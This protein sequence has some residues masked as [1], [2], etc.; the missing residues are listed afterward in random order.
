MNTTKAT[1]KRLNERFIREPAKVNDELRQAQMER[2]F[3]RTIDRL[4]T[5]QAAIEDDQ[6]KRLMGMCAKTDVVYKLWRLDLEVEML[7]ELMRSHGVAPA[8]ET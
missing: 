8:T 4:Q 6:N 3:K 2:A 7:Q 1:T 5:M